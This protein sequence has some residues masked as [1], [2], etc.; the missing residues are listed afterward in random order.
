MIKAL[1]ILLCVAVAFGFQYG[2][3]GDNDRFDRNDRFDIDDDY[4]GLRQRLGGR[5]R[6]VRVI[7]PNVY[8]KY[9]VRS[10]VRRPS[11]HVVR[12]KLLVQF[13][14]KGK[15]VLPNLKWQ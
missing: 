3:Y 4:Y 1:I 10:V 8:P 13:L 5:G 2:Y 6:G 9:A 12:G 7:R 15:R 11:V 14:K